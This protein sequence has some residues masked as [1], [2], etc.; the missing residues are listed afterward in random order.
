MNY[1]EHI[2]DEFVLT[3]GQP[4]SYI[5]EGIYAP[6]V[7]NLLS[8]SVTANILDTSQSISVHFQIK[9]TQ[10]LKKTKEFNPLHVEADA[11]KLSSERMEIGR[12]YPVEYSGKKYLFYKPKEGIIDIYEVME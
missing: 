12:Y 9:D 10:T 7:I 2:P 6:W 5:P 1:I 4:F 3:G 11:I 8:R